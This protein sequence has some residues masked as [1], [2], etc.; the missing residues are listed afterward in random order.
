MRVALSSANSPHPVSVSLSRSYRAVERTPVAIPFE[1][2]TVYAHVRHALPC[3]C[4]VYVVDTYS[5]THAP[6][7]QA[8][9][10]SG[11]ITSALVRSC[12]CALAAISPCVY[13][14]PCLRTLDTV[15]SFTK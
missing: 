5:A 7:K 13:D 3:L 10:T 1:K 9:P 12:I 4:G 11:G 14:A 15:S 2:H 6:V 8:P